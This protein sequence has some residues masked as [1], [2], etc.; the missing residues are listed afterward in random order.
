MHCSRPLRWINMGSYSRK[1]CLVMN[2]TR[3]I[4]FQYCL[5]C[6]MNHTYDVYDFKRYVFNHRK[7]QFVI[8][9]IKYKT[10]NTD[11]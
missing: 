4:C 3:Q 8:K 9:Q 2:R 1:T 6:A 10:V 5:N 11:Y 7:L